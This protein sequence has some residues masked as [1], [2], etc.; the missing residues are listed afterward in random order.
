MTAAL[1]KGSTRLLAAYLQSLLAFPDG[2]TRG[3]NVVDPKDDSLIVSIPP[4][5]QD[6][7]YP[8]EQA[9]IDL[10]LEEKKAGRRVLIYTTHTDTRDLTGRIEQFLNREGV[11]TQVLKSATVKSEN[12]EE[13]VGRKVREGLDALIC[14]PR[15]VQTGLDLVEFPTICWFETD[16]SVYTM[17]QASRRS[18]R[19]GQTRPVKVMFM[20]Y[21]K[22]IQTEALKLVA[23]KMQSSLAV[24][25]ELPEEGLIAFGDDGQDLIMTLARQ[26]VNET[27]FQ[28]GDSLE[29]IFARAREAEQEAERYLV[30]DEW[31]TVKGTA[32]A[33]DK[34]PKPAE[35]SMFSWREFTSQP[36]QPKGKHGKRNHADRQVHARLGSGAGGGRGGRGAGAVNRTTQPKEQLWTKLSVVA[37]RKDRGRDRQWPKNS[38]GSPSHPGTSTGS[39]RP[40]SEYP[41]PGGASAP[42]PT[43]PGES[44]SRTFPAT[45]PRTGWPW[46]TWP[47]S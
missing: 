40:T 37:S 21:E 45:R 42:R 23:K 28:S 47:R 18:W 26:I 1:A 25:G 27:E 14:N 19:I 43:R 11:R 22:T 31:H 38:T 34:P 8:K 15:L 4:L 32:D 9:L 36:L 7:T 29:N 10:V 20:V 44:R 13:W 35:K 39:R 41:P 2:C 3:E 46:E 12:R 30:D 6:E 33:A 24:E 16:Y 17:R 5:D